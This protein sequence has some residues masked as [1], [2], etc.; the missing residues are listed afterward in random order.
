M[1]IYESMSPGERA[2]RARMASHASWANTSDR[3]RRSRPGQAAAF[4]RFEDMVDPDGSLS[5]SERFKRAES[6]RRAH[7]AEIALKS[8]KSR[9][10]KANSKK[11]KASDGK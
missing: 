9:R 7:M 1:T 3:A 8:A 10:A 6:L 4:K 11:N 2:L 5:E